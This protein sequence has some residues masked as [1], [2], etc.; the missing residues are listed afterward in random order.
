MKTGEMIDARC[1]SRAVVRPRHASGHAAAPAMA[2]G[3]HIS[4]RQT[5]QILIWHVMEIYMASS[6]PASAESRKE[7]RL[8]PN[9]VAD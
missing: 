9:T 5:D 7:L 1:A 8:E 6:Q 3:S 2:A 4:S